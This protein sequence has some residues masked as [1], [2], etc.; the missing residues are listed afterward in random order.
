MQ[1]WNDTVANLTLMALG[2]SAP[3]ILL[4]CIE[5]V[6]N[7]FV[8]GDLGPGTIVGSAAFNLFCITGLCVAV[9]PNQESRRIAGI[10]VFV[11]TSLFSLFAYIWLVIVL[12]VIS[13]NKVEIWEAFMTLAMFPILVILA[14]VTDQNCFRKE[15]SDKDDVE[16]GKPLGYGK[17]K[18]LYFKWDKV[19]M[20]HAVR[21]E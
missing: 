1:V 19:E 21:Y 3:E 9:I 16:A 12:V 10:K 11:L 8:A 15:E 5:T 4:A 17:L 14:Y 2:S 13:P 20:S 18:H 7:G 6:G